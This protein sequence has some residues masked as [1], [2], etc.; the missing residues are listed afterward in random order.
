MI[1]PPP[2]T[3]SSNVPIA[4]GTMP[5]SCQTPACGGKPVNASL[6]IPI[7]PKRNRGFTTYPPPISCPIAN[8][9]AG[10]MVSEPRDPTGPANVTS[11]TANNAVTKGRPRG[12]AGGRVE[13]CAT[14]VPVTAKANTPNSHVDFMPRTIA[15]A[16]D[17]VPQLRSHKRV[18]N[19]TLW[20]F[21]MDLSAKLQLLK[22]TPY[23]ASLPLSEIREL[24]PR[25]LERHYRAGDLIFRKGDRSEGLCVVLSGRVRTETTSEEGREQVLKVFGPGRTFADIPAFE[26]EP[27]PANPIT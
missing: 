22:Q 17:L 21:D 24:V 12:P 1:G 16:R 5:P 2:I 10:E 13:G 20:G 18:H 19:Q 8:R 11:G 7:A 26:G 23:F 4:I 3:K 14:A 25:L 15:L 6:K 27:P 9:S